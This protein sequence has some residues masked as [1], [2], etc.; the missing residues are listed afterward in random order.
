M[1]TVK[2]IMINLDDTYDKIVIS[3]DCFKKDSHRLDRESAHQMELDSMFNPIPEI[4][5]ESFMRKENA[6]LD[7]NNLYDLTPYAITF[8]LPSDYMIDIKDIP[9]VKYREYR[10]LKDQQKFLQVRFME[11]RIQ[12][13]LKKFKRC[14]RSMHQFFEIHSYEIYHEFTK[15]GIVHSHGLL[16]CNNNYTRGT[17]DIMANMWVRCN[18]GRKGLFT[19]VKKISMKKGNDHAFDKCNSIANWRKYI[20]KET[21]QFKDKPCYHRAVC[22]TEISYNC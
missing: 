15:Q 4:K 16:L 21:G 20:T 14:M 5:Y 12:E 18:P 22:N 2:S 13:W 11:T 7:P 3:K 10:L 19:G 6:V 17:S 1:T 9:T 8:T